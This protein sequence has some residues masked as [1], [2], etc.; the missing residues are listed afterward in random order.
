VSVPLNPRKANACPG[1]IA[2]KGL[3]GPMILFLLVVIVGAAS[4][5]TRT[6]GAQTPPALPAFLSIHHLSADAPALDVYVDG[7]RVISGL[8]FT[9][10]S[11]YLRL[12]PGAHRVQVALSGRLDQ[13]LNTTASLESGK[14]YTWV[15]SG[16]T[17]SSDVTVPFTPDLQFTHFIVLNNNA[18]VTADMRSR[19]RIV[20]ASPGS[21]PLDVRLDDLSGIPLAS[22]LAYGIVG[23][24]STLGAGN[25]TISVY[26][27]GSSTPSL[28][29]L[30][31]AMEE[32][33]AYTMVIG[34]VLPGVANPDSPNPVQGLIAQRVPD[35]NS[36]RAAVLSP[37]CNQVILNLPV[38]TPIRNI[39]NLV[40]DAGRVTSV[41]RFDNQTKLLKVGYFSDPTAP[42][43]Y[44]N[45][46]AS[47]EAAF[48]CVSAT[49]SWSPPG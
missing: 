10:V 39:L 13:L 9:D 18:G 8:N 38:G 42:L 23:D 33:K 26:A 7:G 43:D 14:S 30:G 47:P 22:A 46:I 36:A 1:R 2:G 37:G 17:S 49:T 31:L 6:S 15:L 4:L 32:R 34:G 48:I 27:A 11:D 16:L 29:H 44:Q 3:R 12:S 25:Y 41:W 40:D 5:H 19:V 24:Y 28:S 35:Q 21:A 45:T 20:N